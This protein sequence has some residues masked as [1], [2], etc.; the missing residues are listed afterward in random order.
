[1]CCSLRVCL[2]RAFPWKVP[3]ST[4]AVSQVHGSVGTWG[5][6]LMVGNLG[7]IVKSEES[8]LA[9]EHVVKNI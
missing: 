6:Q 1:M 2:L 5:L 3:G 8:T 9:L 7:G 4:T